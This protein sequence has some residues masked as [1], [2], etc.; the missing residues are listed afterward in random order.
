MA[1]LSIKYMTPEKLHISQ[2]PGWYS[3]TI[4]FGGIVTKVVYILGSFLFGLSW[5][6]DW[7]DWVLDRDAGLC[8]VTRCN[9]YDRLRCQAKESSTIQV[10]LTDVLAAFVKCDKGLTLVLRTGDT[11]SSASKKQRRIKNKSEAFEKLQNVADEITSFLQLNHMEDISKKKMRSA[12]MEIFDGRS[13]YFDSVSDPSPSTSEV[14]SSG[15]EFINIIYEH[16]IS[17]EVQVAD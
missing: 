5:M 4:L 7:E 3:Y 17:P 1:I 12:S 10:K 14:S 8:T 2:G 6:D 9:W 15:R 11:V 16:P 13:E